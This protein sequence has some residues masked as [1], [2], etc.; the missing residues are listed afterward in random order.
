LNLSPEDKMFF[1]IG[2][3]AGILRGISDFSDQ[4]AR[5]KIQ[6]II[7]SNQITLRNV[8]QIADEMMKQFI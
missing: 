3:R 5:S 1:V 7:H 8:D 2:R 6:E 4:S